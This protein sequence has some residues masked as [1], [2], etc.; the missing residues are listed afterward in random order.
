MQS[1]RS[2]SASQFSIF[3]ISM[4]PAKH[5][6]YT[7]GIDTL[8]INPQCAC[9]AM[10]TV[11]GLSVCG[12]V[13]VCVCAR[14]CLLVYVWACARACVCWCVCVRVRAPVSVGVCVGVCARLCMLV[15]VCACVRA[16]VCW[17]VC[18]PTFILELQAT[19]WHVN[20]TLVFSATSPQKIMWQILPKR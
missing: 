5:R 16:C 17:G 14:L 11:L 3:F 4:C 10:V 20:S 7:H 18:A 8:L 13:C 12:C 19:K 1:L 2:V 6:E 15:C 9:E